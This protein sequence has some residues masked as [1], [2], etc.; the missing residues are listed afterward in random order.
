MAGLRDIIVHDYF[1]IDED[2]IWDV[3]SIRIPE[4]NRH[5]DSMIGGLYGDLDG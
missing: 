4:L 1:G 3:E 5:I 2:I